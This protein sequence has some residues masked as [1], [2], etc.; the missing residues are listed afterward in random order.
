[1]SQTYTV[2]CLSTVLSPLT[3][4]MRTEGNE[5]LINREPIQTPNGMR[6]LPVLSGNA[7]RHR[8]VRA[9]G[10]RSLVERLGLEQKLSMRQLN[11][12]FHGGQL[13][14]GGGRE[15]TAN[16]ADFRRLFPLYRLLGGSLTNQILPGSLIA[17][18]GVLVC[19]ENLARLRGLCPFEV[20]ANI[21]GAEDFVEGWQYTRNDARTTVPDLV[22]AAA[23]DEKTNL[24]PFSGQAVV[25]GAA[26][27]HGFVL[28]NVGELELGALMLSLALWRDSGGTIGG[29]ASRGHGQLDTVVRCEPETEISGAMRAYVAHID[30]TKAEATAWLESAFIAR[31]KKGKNATV[32]SDSNA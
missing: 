8:L 17:E 14:E 16:T 2:H 5:S 20:P 19:R 30:A 31:P 10:A 22:P 11:F 12:L 27:W 21:R 13:T 15:D 32:E 18:R 28:Q 29:Q 6:F 4:A 23:S 7:L 25:P 24:M 26:F 9:P 3:H 1:M